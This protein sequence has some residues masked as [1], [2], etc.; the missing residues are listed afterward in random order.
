MFLKIKNNEKCAVYSAILG[1]YRKY[2]VGKEGNPIS[3][4]SFL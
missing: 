1:I 3:L 4:E 2:F